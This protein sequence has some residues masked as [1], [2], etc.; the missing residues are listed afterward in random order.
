M[1][2]LRLT[3]MRNLMIAILFCWLLAAPP[4]WAA[5]TSTTIWN[6]TTSGSDSNPG[7]FDPGQ[8]GFATDGAATSA[9]TA[10]PVFTSA[11]YTFVAGDVG[12]WLFYQERDKLDSWVVPDRI[13]SDWRGHA[14]SLHRL[15]RCLERHYH[16]I[17]SDY[18]VS[19]VA[20]VATTA[21]PSSATWGVDYSQQ[22]SAQFSFTDLVIA[23]TTT[24][25]TSAGHP[26]GVN[27]VG[28][29]I[30]VTSGTG[31]TTGV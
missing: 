19:T 23:A 12:A 15:R 20:G 3:N 26:F 16:R 1:S 11:S 22:N 17:A 5:I 10:S 13:G 6:M 2:P 8:T 24:N 14:H 25:V 28:N 29:T 30:N 9:N 21:S 18:G 4:S 27:C 31:F 7:G